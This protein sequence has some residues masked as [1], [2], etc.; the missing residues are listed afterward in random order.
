MKLNLNSRKDLPAD[1][2]EPEPVFRG[3]MEERQKI[4]PLRLEGAS[5]PRPE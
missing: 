2:S 1:Q 3:L 5:F 4:L